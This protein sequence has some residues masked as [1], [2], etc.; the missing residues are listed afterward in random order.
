MLQKF[1]YFLFAVVLSVFCSASFAFNS[2][3]TIAYVGQLGNV[4]MYCVVNG[5]GSLSSCNATD[6][7]GGY[8]SAVM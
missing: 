4:T 8:G 2:A 1:K 7:S 3:G 5:N 6:E